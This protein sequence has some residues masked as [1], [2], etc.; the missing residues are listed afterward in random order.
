MDDV[1]VRYSGDDA[2]AARISIIEEGAQRNVR[3][4]NLAIV[5]THS[6]NGVAAIHSQLLKETTVRDLA[7]MFPTRFN[8]KTNGVTPRR[9]L[10]SANPP[11]ASVIT[12]AI[13]DRWITD[14][15]HLQ[16]LKP[17][18]D[19]AGFRKAFLQAKLQAKSQFA[20]W[21]VATSGQ[22][23]KP[24]TMFDCQVKRIH[25]YK[26]QLLNA[27]RVVVLYNRLRAN[28][29]LNVAPRTFLF[30][31]KAAPAYHLAKVIIK[32]I[33]NLA[34][35]ID[36]DPAIKGRIK[37]LF[38]PDYCVT[39]AEHL[40]PA[41]DV[42]NQISTAGY[43]ASGTSNMKF[44]MNGALT[45]GTRDG[46]TIEMAEEAGEENFFLFGL[47]AQQVADT[48]AWYSPY[49]HYNNEPET[50]AALDLIFSGHFNRHEPG[51]LDP[52]RDTLLTHGDTYLHLADLTSYLQ[53][54]EQLVEL[55]TQPD[56][57][58]RKA[59]LNVAGSGKFS[60]DRTI[61]EYASEIWNVAP[62][63]VP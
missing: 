21:L 30:A 33:N 26:R 4:A 45:L 15:S 50:R 37:V 44:M 20:E 24:D 13:G 2:R 47:T 43:E 1:H 10:L 40:I 7:E 14:L 57:W 51:A 42:S 63:P 3:M 48:R 27:L 41:S 17:L 38:L 32:F 12:A 18:A 19:D 54:D 62:F 46:A 23:V 39:L 55:Y 36:G 35:T 5:G 59:I 52:I 9:W 29:S 6:T 31:G 16:K 28:P 34:R 60:S 53:A 58:A 61:A 8:N 49:W 22:T 11:L 56:A 25:E